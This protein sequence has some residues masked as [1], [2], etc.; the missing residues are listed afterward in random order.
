[1]ITVEQI[2]EMVEKISKHKD[3]WTVT[4]KATKE[5]WLEFCQLALMSCSNH[6]EPPKNEEP[7]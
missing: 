3:G 1:M 6:W 4:L 5:E 7:S 2:A